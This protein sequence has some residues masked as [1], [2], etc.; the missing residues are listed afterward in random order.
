M[1]M[2]PFDIHPKT[3]N[4]GTSFPVSPYVGQRFVYAADPA[5]GVFWEFMNIP[6]GTVY[7]W[8][9]M[10]PVPVMV[11]NETNITITP[12]VAW[13]D[14]STGAV[15][16][17]FTVPF[18]GHYRAECTSALLSTAAQ[19]SALIGV[20]FGAAAPFRYAYTQNQSASQAWHMGYLPSVPTG[21]IA[22]ATEVRMRY[23]QT[24]AGWTWTER[25]LMVIPVRVKGKF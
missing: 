17:S 13:G 20:A 7:P 15:G 25:R 16:P 3:E 6:D 12:V 8:K 1:R 11:Q 2:R 14:P 10:G 4:P 19:S 9:A 21:A 18:E 5:N 23:Y 22:A 24:L